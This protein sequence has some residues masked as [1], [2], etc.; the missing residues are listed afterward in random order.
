MAVSL[1]RNAP[2]LIMHSSVLSLYHCREGVMCICLGCKVYIKCSSSAAARMLYAKGKLNAL[3][4]A[5]QT[6]VLTQ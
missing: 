5:L 6:T 2:Q 3:V 4:L 1:S